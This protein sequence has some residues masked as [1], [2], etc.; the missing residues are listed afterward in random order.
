[1]VDHHIPDGLET[2]AAFHATKSAVWHGTED[3]AVKKKKQDVW[4]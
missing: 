2:N 4:D 3:Y 1:V